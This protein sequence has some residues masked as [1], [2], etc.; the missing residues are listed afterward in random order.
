MHRLKMVKYLIVKVVLLVSMGKLNA[1]TVSVATTGGEVAP[2]KSRPYAFSFGST[3]NSNLY[4]SDVDHQVSNTFSL[5]ASYN[6]EKA[7]KLSIAQLMD[8]DLK[9]DR[10]ET[11]NDTVISFSR[12]LYRFNDFTSLSGKI[13]SSLPISKE[14]RDNASL[15]TSTSIS[16]V[17]ALDLN[18]F[19]KGISISYAP[20]F[21]R[22]FHQYKTKA[23][24]ASNTSYSWAQRLIIDYSFSESFSLTLDQS[25]IRGYTYRGMSKDSFSFDQSLN[26]QMNSRVSWS[27]GHSI[28]GSALAVNGKD[29]NVRLFDEEASSVYLSFALSL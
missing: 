26:Y 21:R 1:Q 15:V 29:S 2:T 7:G 24:G 5:G 20:S 12:A 8:K 25:Y 16:P 11:W 19:I 18:N 14:S 23:D 3:L 9:N 13:S 17:L 4:E 6:F 28:G 22:S 10:L 27:L